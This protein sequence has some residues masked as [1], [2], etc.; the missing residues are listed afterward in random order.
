MHEVG[1]FTADSDCDE[2]VNDPE[3]YDPTTRA[4][5][6]NSKDVS[7]AIYHYHILLGTNY[8]HKTFCWVR[9]ALKRPKLQRN[10]LR[11]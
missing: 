2:S 10:A 11:R 9:D 7:H 4:G 6:W 8:I 3:H 5:K 1:D